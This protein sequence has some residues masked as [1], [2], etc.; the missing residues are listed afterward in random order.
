M[1]AVFYFCDEMKAYHQQLPVPN[2]VTWTVLKVRYEAD[3]E[4]KVW[5]DFFIF[6]I[7]YYFLDHA[8]S[9]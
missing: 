3:M 8:V 6:L 1:F 9:N 7:Y 2:G 5:L 4:C